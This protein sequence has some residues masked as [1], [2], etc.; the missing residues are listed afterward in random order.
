MHT[1]RAEIDDPDR[2][3]RWVLKTRAG[4]EGRKRS[5][6]GGVVCFERRKL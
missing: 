6:D 1:Y 2:R 4:A 5:A 3:R